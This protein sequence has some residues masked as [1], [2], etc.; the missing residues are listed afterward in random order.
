MTEPTPTAIYPQCPPCHAPDPATVPA[1]LPAEAPSG[2]DD[3]L[4]K[5]FG[6]GT[7]FDKSVLL[8]HE[9]AADEEDAPTA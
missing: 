2:S 5:I 4:E 3:S 9:Q 7:A 6:R 8:W 1:P